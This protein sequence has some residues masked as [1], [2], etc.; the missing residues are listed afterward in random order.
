MQDAG[1]VTAG[2]EYVL[3]IPGGEYLTPLS[4]L[5]RAVLQARVNGQTL[6]SSDLTFF[7]KEDYAF[8][9]AVIIA[10]KRID[11][12]EEYGLP[13]Y[14]PRTQ[15]LDLEVSFSK[16]GVRL[17]RRFLL[18]PEQ[19]EV[20]DRLETLEEVTVEHAFSRLPIITVGPRGEEVAIK[21]K[22]HGKAIE[23]VPPCHI[24][25]P[26]PFHDQDIIQSL[27]GLEYL[28]IRYPGFGLKISQLSTNPIRLRISK[29]EWQENRRMRVDGKNLDYMWIWEPVNLKKDESRV[30]RYELKPES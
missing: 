14:D 22:A 27:R 24:L 20:T 23:I 11:H 18:T 9:M 1:L 10:G 16:Y 25:Y 3:Q 29:G 30:F 8:D 2:G 6:C 26:H 19:V 17:T 5:G 28:E 12:G 7:N 13:P 15:E 21:G 4:N